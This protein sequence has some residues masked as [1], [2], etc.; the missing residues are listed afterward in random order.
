MRLAAA[1]SHELNTPSAALSS[2]L[3]TMLLARGKWRA[4]PDDNERFEAAFD[5]AARTAMQ[6]TTRLKEIVERTKRLTNLDR[7]EKQVVDMNAFLSD[8]VALS[9]EQILARADV[10]LDLEPL[11]PISCRPQQMAFVLTNLLQ[12]AATASKPKGRIHI[13]SFAHESGAWIE[14]QDEGPG[15]SAERL[16]RLFEPE[17]TVNGGRVEAGNW[18]LY[19]ARGIVAD[20]GGRLQVESTE[21][22]GTT[23]RMMLPIGVT[24]IRGGSRLDNPSVA[25]SFTTQE[26]SPC[27]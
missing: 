11:P 15:I 8:V 12:N 10:K 23:A 9:H 22:Q 2:S 13:R 5:D 26:T 24:D 14:V 3:N 16:S 1:L 19:M 27:H 7:A 25:H 21:G 20:H 17:F 18:S 4:R 6:A